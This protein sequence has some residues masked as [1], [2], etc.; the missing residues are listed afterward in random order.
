MDGKLA[1]DKL[2][3]QTDFSD[4]H[5]IESY[6]VHLEGM[7][8]RDI[9]DLG[10]MPPDSTEKNFAN[11]RFKG[12]MGNLIEER[13]FGY[14]SNSDDRPDFPDAGVE[15]KATCYDIRKKDHKPS[16]GERL[17]ITMIPYD[18]AISADFYSS[19]LWTKCSNILLIYYQR[20]RAIDKYDQIIR[21]TVLF[22]PPKK[23]LAIIE[24]DYRTIVRYIQEGRADELSEGLTTYLGACTKG[25]TEAKMWAEQF[26]PRIDPVTGEKSWTKAKRRAFSFKRQYMDYVLKNYV[27]GSRSTCDHII[28]SNMGAMGFEDY[29]SSLI[30]QHVG[31]TD[32]ELAKMYNLDYTGNKAQWTQIAYRMLGVKGNSAEEFIKSGTSIRVVR[33]MEN[34]HMKE[35]LSFAPFE[36]K[37]LLKEEWETS[38]LRS[39]LETSKFFF[40]TFK[41]HGDTYRLQGCRLWSMD[42]IDIEIHARACWDETRRIIDKGVKLNL[43]YRADGK[44]I[45]SNNLPKTSDNPVMHVRPHASRAA[46]LLTDGTQIGD[47]EHDASE[48]PDGRYMTKQSFWLNRSYVERILGLNEQPV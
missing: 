2:L 29:V 9:L 27:L 14:K 5:S 13:F 39:Y 20:D 6:A 28:A 15:L 10:I 30:M 18:R 1:F 40:V 12:G 33:V 34:N 25:S 19:H 4:A 32:Q 42:G 47:I 38:T 11:K 8:F 24:D 31:K 46:Y 21:H 37:D 7:T 26:Y 17:V 23:D 44:F 45:I 43:E 16:A 3:E 35:S 22:T 36:F 48:L 41:Q